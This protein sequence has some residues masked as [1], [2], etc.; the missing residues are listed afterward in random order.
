MV[1][2]EQDVE[3]VVDGYKEGQRLFSE[4]KFGEAKAVFA[5]LLSEEEHPN[6][7]MWFAR[8]QFALGE[9][10]ELRVPEWILEDGRLSDSWLLMGIF[11]AAMRKDK[12]EV[13]ELLEI[14][15]KVANSKRM[16]V[17]LEATGMQ[18]E[19]KSNAQAVNV[20]R[21]YMRKN[22]FVKLLRI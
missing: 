15:E 21:R 16:R 17:I 12:E 6:Y 20:V 14:S 9:F 22:Q 1:E 2:A 8:C 3:V 18:E 13:R 10:E 11:A 5:G 4:G 7:G 19:T